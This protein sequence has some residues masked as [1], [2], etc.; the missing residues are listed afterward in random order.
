MWNLAVLSLASSLTMI[1]QFF[2]LLIMLLYLPLSPFRAS[3]YVSHFPCH[4]LIQNFSLFMIPTVSQNLPA[5]VCA[6][7]VLSIFFNS[8]ALNRD[9]LIGLPS[10][11]LGRSFSSRLPHRLVSVFP[12]LDLGTFA[13]IKS[14]EVNSG[15]SMG[16]SKS[17]LH[18]KQNVL[19]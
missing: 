6:H 15:G 7:L 18:V 5:S 8:N 16:Q 9:N 12:Y 11:Y 4:W 13:N 2:C 3:T 10:S 17:R 14:K 1:S 19:F